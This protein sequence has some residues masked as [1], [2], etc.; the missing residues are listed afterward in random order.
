MYPSSFILYHHHFSC[1]SQSKAPELQTVEQGS[2]LW[3]FLVNYTLQPRPFLFPSATCSVWIKFRRSNFFF[4]PVILDI[5]EDFLGSYN[6]FYLKF[7]SMRQ[8]KA[9]PK[10]YV[11]QKSKNQF[12]IIGIPWWHPL[13]RNSANSMKRVWDRDLFYWFTGKV[14][15]NVCLNGLKVRLKM[16]NDQGQNFLF[17]RKQSWSLFCF[18]FPLED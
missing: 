3:Y 10:L 17:H 13:K 18:F 14:P 5:R 6:P 9:K 7:P 11:L 2:R 8:Q 16:A 1:S 4:F 12:R 15:L